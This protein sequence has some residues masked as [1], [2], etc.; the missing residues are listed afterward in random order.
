MKRCQ[1]GGNQALTAKTCDRGLFPVAVQPQSI[2]DCILANADKEEYNEVS[3]KTSLDV[4]SKRMRQR[5]DQKAPGE[6]HALVA[7]LRAQCKVTKI[8]FGTSLLLVQ[9]T[10]VHQLI[11][12]QRE[13]FKVILTF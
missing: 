8:H 12:T 6:Y 10:E 3:F 9:L 7:C 5:K 1:F 4:W 11:K 2:A 13:F